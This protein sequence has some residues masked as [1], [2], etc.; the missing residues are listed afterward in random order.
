MHNA[1]VVQN[2]D[3]GVDGGED[4]PVEEV[5]VVLVELLLAAYGVAVGGELLRRNVLERGHARQKPLGERSIKHGP[6]GKTAGAG[7]Q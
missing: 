6:K 3:Q 4:R 2:F 1:T 5:V 7:R